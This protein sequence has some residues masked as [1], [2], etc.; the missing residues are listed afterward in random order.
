[1]KNDFVLHL[2]KFYPPHMGGMETHL[3]NLVAGISD[4][5]SV[6]V[7][8]ASDSRRRSVDQLDG[9]R[10]IRVPTFGVLASMPITPTLPWELLKVRPALMQVHVPNPGAAFAIVVARYHGP[11]IVM[12]QSDTL[13]RKFLKRLCDPFVN[14][15][16][17]RADRI[18]VASQRYLDSSAEL[19]PFRQ[20]CQVIPMGIT[21]K[22]E[23][24]N[25]KKE[26]AKI[27]QKYGPKIILAVGRMVAYKGFRYLLEAMQMVDAT[28][29]LIG[30]GPLEAELKQSARDLG[31]D[32]KVKFLGKVDNLQKYYRASL[33]FVLPSISRAEAFGLVQLEAMAAGIP[34]VNTNLD[35]GVPEVSVNRI[36]GFTVPPKDAVSL[37]RAVNT[38]LNDEALRQ[39]MGEAG[40]KRICQEFNLKLMIERTMKLYEEILAERQGHNLSFTGTD[41]LKK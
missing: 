25:C 13:G 16:M 11:L 1:L 41:A 3:Q 29:L 40:R 34:V 27:V 20:K 28:L 15:M 30:T 9:A 22:K 35:S 8:V 33:V 10:I 5:L 2:G 18:I 19:A 24:E 26:S 7:I 23:S 36:T 12:H 39:K 37:A 17:N 14:A 32:H 38:L 4:S 31:V 6:Q 21:P